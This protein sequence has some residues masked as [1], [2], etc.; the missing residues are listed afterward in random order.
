LSYSLY[1]DD[2]KVGVEGKQK[3]RREL[4]LSHPKKKTG[5]KRTANGNSF[6]KISIGLGKKK[7]KEN[8]GRRDTLR[9][10]K[11]WPDAPGK[12]LTGI[13]RVRDRSKE[14]GN[15]HSIH[16]GGDRLDL[17]T[18]R[19]GGV[20]RPLKDVQKRRGPHGMWERRSLSGK[21]VHAQPTTQE[22]RQ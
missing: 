8:Q 6:R 7:G 14:G 2:G 20:T 13:R 11:K 1:H 17:R 5:K 18:L 16:R 3:K 9:G 4:L 21:K 22:I 19:Q 10:R 15:L 12:R